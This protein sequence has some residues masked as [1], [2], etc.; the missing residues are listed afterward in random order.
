MPHAI[1]SAKAFVVLA[2]VLVAGAFAAE[3]V[4][5]KL[6]AYKSAAEVTGTLRN[7]GSDATR[8][9]MAFWAEGFEKHHPKAKI[10]TENHGATTAPAG[11][12]A[13]TT[14]LGPMSREWKQSEIDAFEKKFGYK[15]TCL[16]VALD[17]LAVCVH[18]DNPIKQLSLEQLDA[19]FSR[20][21][22]AGHEKD[23]ANW[24][25]LGLKGEWAD[26]PIKVYIRNS[27]AGSTAFF[28]Q[29]VLLGGD[30]KE[31]AQELA[32]GTMVMDTVAT[33]KAGI[34]Y[35]LPL[36][37]P[38]DVRFVPL[39]AKGK[40]EAV[41]FENANV[42]TGTYPLARQIILCINYKPKSELDALRREFIRYIVSKEGQEYAV[43]AGFVP[44]SAE[45]AKQALESVGLQP[46]K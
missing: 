40:K 28:K 32:G 22:K 21:R 1:Q 19:I 5:P 36:D 8:E 43:K 46:A 15:P 35:T 6:P 39:V 42:Q 45:L 13:G 18:K 37:G 27:V 17:A 10:E 44:I 3:K 12:I 34:G 33:E 38:K 16:K 4:D 24:G 29:Q 26:K 25:D 11:L 14:D 30:F 41:E 9:L 2:V 20:N 23:I 31:T 7:C